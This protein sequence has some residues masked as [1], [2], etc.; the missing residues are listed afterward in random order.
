MKNLT[1]L[2]FALALTLNMNLIV[3]AD[4]ANLALG[5]DF[6][7]AK[8]LEKWL[9]DIADG[10]MGEMKIDKT[11]AAIGKSSLFFK[12][13][14]LS[15][16]D[17]TRP[18]FNQFGHILE[19]GKTYTLSAFYKAEEKRTASITAQLNG[20][21]WT[22]FVEKTITIDIQWKEEWATFIAPQ[23]GEVSIQPTRNTD[24]KVNY[25]VDGIRFFVGE[26]EPYAPAKVVSNPGKLSI[27]W[28]FMKS[29][30]LP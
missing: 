30:L 6:E 1:L 24:S 11:T 28:G 10:S 19:K 14:A 27:K 17:G 7:D 4:V 25:W 21:P 5:G 16:K 26:Y 13:T 23:D 18:R 20:D 22:R 29:S 2:L 9:L 3:S 8:D 15:G 12:I